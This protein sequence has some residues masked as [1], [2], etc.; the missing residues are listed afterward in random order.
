MESTS[1]ALAEKL[2]GLSNEELKGMIETGLKEYTE[3]ALSAAL[4]ELERRGKVDG[5]K[6]ASAPEPPKTM[7][8]GITETGAKKKSPWGAIL[9]V[10]G[11]FFVYNTVLFSMLAIVRSH[12]R[13]RVP[14]Q[15]II[16]ILLCLAVAVICLRSGSQRKR[17][18]Q[19]LLGICLLVFGGLVL[20]S[21]SALARRP[22]TLAKEVMVPTA[23]ILVIAGIVVLLFGHIRRAYDK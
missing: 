1:G 13:L 19:T 17:N 4:A 7:V 23:I 15:L 2:K 14:G 16:Q 21:S 12:A 6:P 20:A 8:P 11:A 10:I 18:W 9:V 22:N 5:L 3:E